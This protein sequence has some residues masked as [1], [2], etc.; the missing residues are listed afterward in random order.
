RL[1]EGAS[2]WRLELPPAGRSALRDYGIA[3]WLDDPACPVDGAVR[4][5]LE[6]TVAALRAAGCRVDEAARPRLD[7]AAAV[8]TYLQLLMPIIFYQGLRA[9]DVARL[10]GPAA[11]L[12]P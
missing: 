8:R 3:A 6:A 10:G 9:G 7:L 1:P 2:A 5:R 11:A 4:A 12:A